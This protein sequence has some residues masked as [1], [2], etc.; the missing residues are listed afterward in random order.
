VVVDLVEHRL[1]VALIPLKLHLVEVEEDRLGHRLEEV[2][3]DHLV[4]PNLAF[5]RL[6]VLRL[7][8]LLVVGLLDQ[9]PVVLALEFHP[10]H[11]MHGES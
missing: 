4:D 8:S 1:L 10:R 11:P 7:E 3:V 2:V 6:V 5:H 9:L